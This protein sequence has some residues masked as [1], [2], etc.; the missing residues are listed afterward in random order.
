MNVLVIAPHPD[1][2]A[3]GCGGS[4]CLHVGKGNRVSVVFLSSGEL[5]LKH[6]PPKSAMQ[7]R[8]G[9][10]EAAA[11]ILG[12]SQ[13]T[14]LRKPDYCIGD[15]VEETAAALSPIL[16]CSEPA[17]IYLPHPDEWHPD[18]RIAARVIGLA[19]DHAEITAPDLLGYEV[20]TPLTE[21]DHLKDITAV[22]RQKIRAVRCYKSQLPGYR[23]DRAVRGLNMYRGALARKAYAEVFHRVDADST[24]VTAVSS[25]I[26]TNVEGP[27]LET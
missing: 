2:E 3:I 19:I 9:E 23:Y 21:Y 18:H 17:L 14:F 24:R 27:H 5:G 10:A 12:I 15:R 16:K 8:E 13:L 20:W 11:E 26:M 7:I 1:D 22:I 6:L 4:I 25:H